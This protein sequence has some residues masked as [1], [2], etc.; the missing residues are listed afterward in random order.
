MK[1]FLTI[2]T[3][4]FVS[5]FAFFILASHVKYCKC[6]YSASGNCIPC[7]QVEKDAPQVKKK[8]EPNVKTCDCGY[9]ATGGCLPC[10]KSTEERGD[11]DKREEDFYHK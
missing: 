10:P 7:E 1:I 8:S 2:S 9:D 6:G 3:F 4:L 11:G 5:V